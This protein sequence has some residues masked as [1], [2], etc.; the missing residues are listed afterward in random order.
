AV[1]VI[2][3]INLNLLYLLDRC[4]LVFQFLVNGLGDFIADIRYGRPDFS[5]VRRKLTVI[6]LRPQLLS[7]MGFPYLSFEKIQIAGRI[8]TRLTN[9][10]HECRFA[11]GVHTANVKVIIMARPDIDTGGYPLSF[12]S[13]L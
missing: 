11:N 12:S 10:L 9:S 4:T 8:I 7:Q 1:Q 3:C 13:S 6:N 5:Q 2:I